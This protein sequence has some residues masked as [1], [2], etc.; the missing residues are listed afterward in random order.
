MGPR[1]LV[2]RFSSIGDIVLTS[3]VVRALKNQ[4]KAEICFLTKKRFVS[5]VQHDPH[6]DQIIPWP[7][8]KSL[9]PH[10]LNE[11]KAK[12]FDLI[13]DLHKNLRSARIQKAL[14]CRVVQFDKINMRKWLAVRT[15]NKRFLPQR[16]LVD[17][18]FE[19]M[20]SLGIKNDGKGLSFFHP[21]SNT[22]LSKWKIKSRTY[23]CIAIGGSYATKR[24]PKE[25]IIEICRALRHNEI[26]IIGGKEDNETGT[27]LENN[28]DKVKS[29]CGKINLLESALIIDHCALI[30]T[31]DTGMMHIGAAFQKPIISIWGNT[32]PEFGMYPYG[33]AHKQHKAFEIDLGCRPCSKLG[34]NK[35]PKGHFRCM[36]EQSA[37]AIA[38]FANSLLVES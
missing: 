23:A 17:R 34:H 28:V 10:V 11:L 30:I 8:E 7:D 31:H 15:K 4:L 19:G 16:H 22:D 18:Y 25:K 20:S 27:Y 13:I 33:L 2:I 26:V 3:P 12:N 38:K 1:L 6:I 24:L 36:K 9:I 35:C 21:Y 14:G 32:I 5:L 29:L 37:T